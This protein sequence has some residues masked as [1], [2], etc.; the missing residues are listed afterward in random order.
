MTRPEDSP[1]VP[2]S[3]S[4]W[5]SS[6]SLLRCQS[7]ASLITHISRSFSGAV[8]DFTFVFLGVFSSH[9][10][11]SRLG[12]LIHP[13]LGVFTL[14]LVC[15]L[16]LTCPGAALQFPPSGFPVSHAPGR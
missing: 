10:Y 1:P 7:W 11:S 5:S 3:A 16:L 13:A 8:M 12:S 4:W 9:I 2:P 6:G 14:S 15:M